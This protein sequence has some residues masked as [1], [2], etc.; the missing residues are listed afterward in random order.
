[1]DKANKTI[2]KKIKDAGLKHWQVAQ[3]IGITAG[4]LVLWLRTPLKPERKARVLEAI[5]ALKAQ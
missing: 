2:R 5:E 1:M 4:T 3:Q